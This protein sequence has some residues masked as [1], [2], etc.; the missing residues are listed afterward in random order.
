MNR[1]SG[2]ARRLTSPHSCGVF[3]AHSKP[4]FEFRRSGEPELHTRRANARARP[5]SQHEEDRGDP[6]HAIC[7]SRAVPSPPASPCRRW[8]WPVTT[9]RWATGNHRRRN[10]AGQGAGANQRIRRRA[11]RQD[12]RC[13]PTRTRCATNA[14][15]SAK[16]TGARHDHSVGPEKNG[17]AWEGG[18][19]LDPKKARCTAARPSWWTAQAGSAR[20]YGVSLLGRSAGGNANRKNI[21]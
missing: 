8:R 21:T 5:S 1:D 15:A 10:Q 16:T 7:H 12:H 17:D 19:I 3:G 14:T 13:S 18:K 4:T 6:N 9:L 20:L 11:H 2:M